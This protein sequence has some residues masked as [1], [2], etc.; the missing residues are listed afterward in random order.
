[1]ILVRQVLDH[2]RLALALTRV[3]HHTWPVATFEESSWTK[4]TE[5][6][7]GVFMNLPVLLTVDDEPSAGFSTQI[8]LDFDGSQIRAT[9]VGVRSTAGLPVTG[10]ELRSVRVAGLIA[11]HLPR[12]AQTMS[13]SRGLTKDAEEIAALRDAGPGYG[14]TLR[15]VADN[16]SFARAIGLPPAKYVQQVLNAPR[17][18][19][20]RW[21][22]RA[23]ELGWIDGDD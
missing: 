2:T 17:P 8:E 7:P 13:D 20:T 5:V 11:E 15:F 10:T 9:A 14:P 1:M 4:P 23:K 21:I 19:V 22:R 3:N 6:G 18:T 12:H 16:Y